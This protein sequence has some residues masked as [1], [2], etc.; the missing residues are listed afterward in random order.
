M[1]FRSSKQWTKLIFQTSKVFPQV[2]HYN[3]EG[4][5]RKWTTYLTIWS[6]MPYHWATLPYA[7]RQEDKL[8][9]R[10][11]S[12]QTISSSKIQ[13]PVINYNEIWRESIIYVPG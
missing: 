7:Q 1:L 10:T 2:S 4:S 11:I 13:K 8:G 12:K 6:R 5:E 9:L 3:E